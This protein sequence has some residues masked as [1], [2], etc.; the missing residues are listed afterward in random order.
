MK[1]IPNWVGTGSIGLLL[2]LTACNNNQATPPQQPQTQSMNHAA[3]MGQHA[4]TV[5]PSVDRDKRLTTNNYGT[6]FSGM[7]TSVY[8][9]IGSSN[10]HGGGPSTSLEARLQ[11]AGIHGV[12]TLILN[13]VILVC[14]T[15]ANTT[16]INQMDPMQSHLL[17][18]FSGSSAR[19]GENGSGT[20]G[21]AGTAG[22][23]G[24]SDRNHTLTQART[25]IERIYGSEAKVWTITSSKGIQAFEQVKKQMRD[26]KKDENMV[27]QIS[28]LLR[29]A[30]HQP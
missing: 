5:I 1:R 19:G 4:D 24:A 12:Q 22:T 11:A 3:H 21:T 20:A 28:N 8:S 13:D 10:L 9:N 18:S 15:S 30:K 16:S 25:Q 2:L 7:G 14:P 17:S 26:N 29:E 27:G 6:T 23:L